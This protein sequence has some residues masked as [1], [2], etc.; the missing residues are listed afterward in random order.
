MFF[1]KSLDMFFFHLEDF[2]GS[3]GEVGGNEGE[4]VGKGV[5]SKGVG[6]DPTEGDLACYREGK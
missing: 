3:E 5:L 1:V 6:F 4:E 2:V